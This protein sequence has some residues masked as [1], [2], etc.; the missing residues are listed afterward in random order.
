MP[1][2]VQR[3]AASRSGAPEQS[4]AAVRRIGAI[5]ESAAKTPWQAKKSSQKGC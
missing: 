4:N 3:D 5:A 2:D 1:L